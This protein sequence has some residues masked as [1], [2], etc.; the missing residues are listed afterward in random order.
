MFSVVS[1]SSIYPCWTGAADCSLL[2]WADTKQF[3]WLIIY[4]TVI[5][6]I[7]MVITRI[8]RSISQLQIPACQEKNPP[9]EIVATPRTLQVILW[10]PVGSECFSWG[11]WDFNLAGIFTQKQHVSFKMVQVPPCSGV[12][13]SISC[14]SR[15]TTPAKQ[16]CLFRSS[17][18][19]LI[20]WNLILG[21]MI[22]MALICSPEW[23]SEISHSCFAP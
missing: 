11:L 23:A 1:C 4:G 14:L 20:P 22:R 6:N 12:R 21:V 5:R 16:C 2:T 3:R 17:L 8:S 7:N 10:D 9:R 18:R 19:N 13:R 15:A